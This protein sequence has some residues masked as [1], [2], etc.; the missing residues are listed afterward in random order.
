VREVILIP[1]FGRHEL[2]FCC[3][4]RVRSIEP[5][6]EIHLFPDRATF[7]DPLIQTMAR[8]FQVHAHFVPDHDFYGNTS[9][10]LNAYLFAFNAGYDRVFYLESD[11]MPHVDFFSWH[12]EQQEEFPDIFA[13]MAWIF[14]RHA[15]IVD[16]LL[17]QNWLYSIGLCISRKKLSLVVEHATPK[18]FGDMA[19]Y[20]ERTFPRS[21]FNKNYDI[22]NFAEQDGLLQRIMERDKSQTVCPGIAKCSHVGFT[23]SYG[24]DTQQDYERFLG[25]NGLRFDERVE[26]VEEFIADPY[27]RAQV[28][29]RAIV[30][31][32]IGRE[33]PKREFL[34]RITFGEWETTF[35]SEMT[36]AFLPRRLNSV[37]I[38]KDA[39]LVIMS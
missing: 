2:L 18:Y 26:R 31:R 4:K 34:Y 32:E 13:S 7:H 15:P 22:G 23:R 14:N 1:Q 6:I 20:I 36:R 21:M 8:E 27:W 16:D 33:L 38:P 29:G 11:V 28:F 9:N 19:G 12:R 10:V 24:D 30:E 35:K 17:F 25:L 5:K 37:N 39:E 3:L